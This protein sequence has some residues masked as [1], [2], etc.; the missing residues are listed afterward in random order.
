RRKE[1]AIRLALGAGRHR[2][3]RQLTVEGLLLGLVGG[4]LGILLA[5]WGDALLLSLRTGAFRFAPVDP[6]LDGRV[7]AF[8]VGLA[9]LTGLVFGLVRALQSLRFDLH[10]ALK[11]ETTGFT[12][13][14]RFAVRRL[15][16]V[17]RV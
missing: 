15:L 14:R 1:I 4:S 6:T 8:T 2:I 17:T 9:V 3:I 12:G 5:Q 7:L 16:D 13:T 10:P 11:E